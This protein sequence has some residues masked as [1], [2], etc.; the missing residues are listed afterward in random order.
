M[1]DTFLSWEKEKFKPRGDKKAALV[2]LRKLRKGEVKKMVEEKVGG[3]R[4]KKKR[5]NQP[6]QKV[7]PQGENRFNIEKYKES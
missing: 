3:K 5:G 6:D 1:S 7:S 2:G 4:E